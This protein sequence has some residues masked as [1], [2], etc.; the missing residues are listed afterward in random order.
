MRPAAPLR[1]RKAVSPRFLVKAVRPLA[2]ATRRPQSLGQMLGLAQTLGAAAQ[3]K[4]PS[5]AQT[6]FAVKLASEEAA[7][8]EMAMELVAKWQA[9]SPARAGGC[10]KGATPSRETAA[11]GASE[12]VPVARATQAVRLLAGAHQ[13]QA[14]QQAA[15][16]FHS[17]R[18][19][20]AWQHPQLAERAR[21]PQALSGPRRK[22]PQAPPQTRNLGNLGQTPERERRRADQLLLRPE[23]SS[24]L[25]PR[26]LPIAHRRELRSWSG[27]AKCGSRPR[28]Q[29][30]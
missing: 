8:R 11:A 9:E 25:A 12:A 10:A 24:W 2:P 5:P 1:A 23:D 27:A 4:H 16:H 29:P 13:R 22:R 26:L 19:A 21:H 28:R 30:R 17:R 15:Q 3:A 6:V 14:V 20:R 18:A 7:T